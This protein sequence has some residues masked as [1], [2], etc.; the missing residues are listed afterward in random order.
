MSNCSG[1]R[2][3]EEGANM[4]WLLTKRERTGTRTRVTHYFLHRLLIKSDVSW[5]LSSCFAFS[6]SSIFFLTLLASDSINSVGDLI[7]FLSHCL[8]SSFFS[9]LFQQKHRERRP[10]FFFQSEMSSRGREESHIHFRT[11]LSYSSYIPRV[12]FFLSLILCL[13]LHF[14]SLKWCWW[15]QKE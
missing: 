4:E 13:K 10:S 8:S 1:N 3:D 15:W 2:Q 7:S 12:S 5:I 6:F 9:M 14:F 11:H